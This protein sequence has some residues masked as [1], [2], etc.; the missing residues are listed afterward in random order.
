MLPANAAAADFNVC[1]F[2]TSLR[3]IVAFSYVR[4]RADVIYALDRGR[5]I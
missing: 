1:F 3:R 4:G 5:I 2:F